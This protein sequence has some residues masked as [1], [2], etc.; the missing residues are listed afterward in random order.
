MS[1]SNKGAFKYYINLSTNSNSNSRVHKNCVTNNNNNN[2]NT[3]D[4]N[5]NNNKTTTTTTTKTATTSNFLGCDS[6]E[7]NLVIVHF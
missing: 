4:N 3:I 6:I 1:W 7:L 2:N 5:K